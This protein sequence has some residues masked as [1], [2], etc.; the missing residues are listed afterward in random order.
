MNTFWDLDK[1]NLK[2]L[3]RINTIAECPYIDDEEYR[4]EFCL[5]VELT[6]KIYR[7]YTLE[8]KVYRFSDITRNGKR[9]IYIFMS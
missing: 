2:T 1:C 7:P 4:W 3:G 5:P 9:S 8:E 6:Q